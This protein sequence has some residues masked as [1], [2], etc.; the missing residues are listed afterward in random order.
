METAWLVQLEFKRRDGSTTTAQLHGTRWLLGRRGDCDVVIPAGNLA[1]KEQQL[2]VVDGGL[3]LEPTTQSCSTWV[4]GKRIRGATRLASAN[5]VYVSDFSYRLL[6]EPLP[7][8]AGDV[9][10]GVAW[11]EPLER[12]RP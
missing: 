8:P 3:F 1:A 7:L 6:G 11:S 12:A 2:F 5:R 4:D 10:P 9:R